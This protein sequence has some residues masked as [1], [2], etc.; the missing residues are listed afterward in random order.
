MLNAD[1]RPRTETDLPACVAVLRQVHDSD[2]YP[3]AWPADPTR[4]LTPRDVLAGW[5]LRDDTGLVGHVLLCAGG[6]PDPRVTAAAGVPGDRL[7]FVSRLFVAPAAR[8][9]G[10][11]AVLLRHAGEQ[12]EQRGLRLALDVVEDERGAAV[13]LYERSGWQRL[14]TVPATWTAPDGTR[15]R[16]HYYLSPAPAVD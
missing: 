2:G 1:I 13:A 10:A 6:D 8:R 15:P 7:A 5:V 16:V 4:W 11:G 3:M 12:A 14:A 9:R